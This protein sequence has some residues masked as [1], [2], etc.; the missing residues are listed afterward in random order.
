M[1]PKGEAV[2]AWDRFGFGFL[3]VGPIRSEPIQGGGLLQ[4]AN[5]GTVTLGLPQPGDSVEA[6]VNR[7]ESGANGIHTPLVARILVEGDVA[8]HRAA[9][10]V[11]DCVQKLQPLVAGFAIECEPDVA[12]NEWHGREWEGFWTRLQQLISAAKPPA[13]VWWVRRLDQ[14]AT[15]GNLQAAEGQALLA[16]VLLEARTLGPA[17]L[18]CGGVDEASVIDAVRA[19]RAGLGAGRSLIVASGLSTPGQAVRLLRAGSDALLVD[20]GMV[21]SGPGLPKRINEAVA[22]TRSN[23]P[24]IGPASDEGSIFRFSWLW[25]LLLGVG[26]FT[27]SMLAIW[28]ALTRVVLPYDEV[29]CGLTRGQLAA[30][31]RHLLP[32]MAHDRMILAGTMLNIAVLYLCSSWFGIRRG[33]HWCRT[34]AA[35]SAGAGFLSFF[36][37]LG[38]GYFDPFHA[39]VTTVLF[40]LFVQG[41]VGRVAP[42]TLPDQG[43]E[44]AETVEW[45]MGQ[46]GQLVWVVHSVG[47]LLAGVT[48][49]G[50]G[51]ADVLISTDER[52]LG[53]S[54]AELRVAAGRVLPLIAH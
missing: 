40:Q 11:A 21:F 23:P 35:C 47:L 38:F 42:T 39:F 2:R 14:C 52:Y 6:L 33:R 34:A 45:R 32:F 12:R 10:W 29:Y 15:F 4:D 27:G 9:T 13:R 3:E 25:T 5:A 49:S 44:W 48:I 43:V 19:L 28:F 37:F 46:W 36:L 53:I 18:V 20:T 50:V 16:G 22:T 26:M 30:L 7:L 24:S 31:N 8:P 1:D 17:G 51:I 54:V 41:L